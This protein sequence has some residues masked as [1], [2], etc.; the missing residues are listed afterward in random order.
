MCTLDKNQHT[1]WQERQSWHLEIGYRQRRIFSSIQEWTVRVSPVR[2]DSSSLLSTTISYYYAI[3]WKNVPSKCSL[4]FNATVKPLTEKCLISG[5]WIVRK[6]G[7]ISFNL[8]HKN[9]VIYDDIYV[10]MCITTR[11][12]S[13]QNWNMHKYGK[14]KVPCR[15]TDAQGIS[16]SIHTWHLVFLFDVAVQIQCRKVYTVQSLEWRRPRRTGCRRSSAGRADEASSRE[17]APQKPDRPHPCK[18]TST[19]DDFRS[20][21]SHSLCAR[22]RLDGDVLFAMRLRDSVSNRKSVLPLHFYM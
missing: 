13:K 2:H 19:K 4:I 15:G 9:S 21:F 14:Q 11:I 22:R 3:S 17:Y 6:L 12:S 7:I 5:F 16:G 10:H 8:I 1:C 18:C 20:M